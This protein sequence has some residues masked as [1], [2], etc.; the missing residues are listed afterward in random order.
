VTKSRAASV[1]YWTAER[2]RNAVPV[3][4][5][6]GGGSAKA[7]QAAAFSSSNTASTR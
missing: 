1:D 5:P 3:E 7:K 6:R 4:R 2:M